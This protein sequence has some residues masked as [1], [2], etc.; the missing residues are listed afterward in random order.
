MGQV[1]LPGIMHLSLSSTK[2]KKKK[3]W[4]YETLK[5]STD[6]VGKAND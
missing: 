4:G 5:Q 1:K 2:Q 3:Y 6:S